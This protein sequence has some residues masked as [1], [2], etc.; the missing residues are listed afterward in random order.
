MYYLNLSFVFKLAC[1]TIA[2]V[3]HYTVE[4][5]VVARGASSGTGKLVACVSLGL[6]AAVLFGGLFIGFVGSGLGF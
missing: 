3:F 2:I 5:K 6:W 1:L 4:R